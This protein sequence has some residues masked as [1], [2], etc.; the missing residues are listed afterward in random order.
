MSQSVLRG[1]F[2][3]VAVMDDD[4]PGAK[5]RQ[6]LRIAGRRQPNLID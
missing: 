5:P 4:E 3:R 2:A 1:A 6:D